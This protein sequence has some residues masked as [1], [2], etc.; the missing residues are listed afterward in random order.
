MRSLSFPNGFDWTR[1]E[2][3]AWC[4]VE[5]PRA[6]PTFPTRSIASSRWASTRSRSRARARRRTC[7]TGYPAVLA[8]DADARERWLEKELRVR[9]LEISALGVHGPPLSPD[10]EVK[11]TYKRQFADACLLAEQIGVT[12][13]TLLGG[14]PEAAE[15]DRSPAWVVNAFPL[16]QPSVARVAVGAAG[17]PLLDRAGQTGRGP[18]LQAVLRDA[19]PSDVVFNPRTLLRLREAVGPVVGVNFDPSHLLLQGIDPLEAIHLLGEAIYHVHAKDT[20]VGARGRAGQRGARREAVQQRAGARV[21][22]PHRRLRPRRALLARLRQSCGGRLR[23]RGVDRAR[24]RVLSILT[25][26]SRR[27]PSSSSR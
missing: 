23:R 26:A 18:R 13:L 22:L 9:E 16:D 8:H 5:R 19:S 1:T 21:A 14:L 10:P 12:R 6:A 24:G 27:A 7:A 15:G 2:H 25:R 20:Q 11:Q 3:E 4:R 17:D